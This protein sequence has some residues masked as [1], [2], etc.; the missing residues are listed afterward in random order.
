M[1]KRFNSKLY[2]PSSFRLVREKGKYPHWKTDPD[3]YL[4]AEGRYRT[5]ILPSDLPDWYVKGYLYKRH[6]F[7]SA[8]GVV[9]IIYEPNYYIENHWHKYDSLYVSYTRKMKRVPERWGFTRCED[10]DY[11]MDAGIAYDFLKKVKKYSPDFD[12]TEIERE[13]HLKTCWFNM[14]KDGGP[15]VITP[16]TP[17]R[18]YRADMREPGIVSVAFNDGSYWL[19]DM[20]ALA[21]KLPK[22]AEHLRYLDEVQPITV[23][24][25][26]YGITFDCGLHLSAEECFEFKVPYPPEAF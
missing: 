2:L 13:L 14:R 7:L 15:L 11:V 23:D 24:L 10:Y 9:D 5:K 18:V 8:K 22:V 1:S 20:A 3:G 21:E 17:I 25:Y 4:W 26:Y 16:E 19:L 12:T 6:G